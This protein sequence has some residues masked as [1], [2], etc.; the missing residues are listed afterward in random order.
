MN[1]NPSTLRDLLA[2]LGVAYSDARCALDHGDP[3]QLVVA[4]VLSAQC[5][6][7][8]VNQVT[9]GLFAKYPTPAA[10]AA[11]GTEELEA[12]IHSTGF[13]RNKARN[14]IGLGRAL[15]ERHDSEVPRDAAALAALPGVGRKTA[16]V[17]L[18]NAF[19]IPALAVDTH[20]YRVARR[21]DLSRGTTPETVEAD[22]CR[23]FPKDVWISLHHQLIWHGR[24]VC[25][26]RKPRCG[27]CL[28]QSL[29]PVGS[30]RMVDPHGRKG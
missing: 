10:L 24:L 18:A 28:L 7:A 27:E 19:G 25:D 8:R 15:V 30:G 17:V 5:T 1:W 11:A 21:L 14:L 29:C 13:F 22:L 12:L 9:P 2:R 26:A 20:V 3:F 23:R 6:D 16:N 4:T